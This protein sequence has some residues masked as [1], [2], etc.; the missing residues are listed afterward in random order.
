MAT[1]QEETHKED[2]DGPRQS[3]GTQGGTWGRDGHTGLSMDGQFRHTGRGEHT[4]PKGTP[5]GGDIT[6]TASSR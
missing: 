4:R 3:L 1:Q 5:S 2:E 6:L